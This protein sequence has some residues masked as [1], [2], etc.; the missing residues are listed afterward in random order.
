MEAYKKEDAGEVNIKF[1][2]VIL[3]LLFKNALFKNFE[4]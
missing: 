4:K 1:E 2:C 3:E